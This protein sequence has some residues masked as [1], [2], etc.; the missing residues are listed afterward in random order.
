MIE[1]T[2]IVFGVMLRFVGVREFQEDVRRLI[3]RIAVT[4]SISDSASWSPPRC[5]GDFQS[6]SKLFWHCSSS[7]QS[8]VFRSLLDGRCIQVV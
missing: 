8:Q 3:I 5:R 6:L 7:A 2:L 1:G 4:G